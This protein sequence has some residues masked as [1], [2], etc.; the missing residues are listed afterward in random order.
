GISSD[1][2]FSG[3]I[4]GEVL[5]R[6]R[7]VLDH[8]RQQMFLEPNPNFSEPY[9]FDMSGMFL[10][11]GSDGLDKIQVREVLRSSPA[12]D[13]GVRPGDVIAGVDNLAAAQLSLERVRKFLKE[14]EGKEYLL[15]LQRGA[16]SLRVKI[17]LRRLI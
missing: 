5:R 10:T 12:F 2:S 13:A 3:I 16:R 9:D 11:A 17:Q 14:R 1:D 15:I 8:P 7:L 6:F 4:G